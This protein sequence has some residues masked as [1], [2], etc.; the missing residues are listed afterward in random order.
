LKHLKDLKTHKPNIHVEHFAMVIRR[1]LG[2]L[3]RKII[4]KKPINA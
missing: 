3:D 2:F 1:G 4:E